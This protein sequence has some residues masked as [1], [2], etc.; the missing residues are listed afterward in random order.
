MVVCIVVVFAPDF[1]AQFSFT[2]LTPLREIS[3]TVLFAP[4]PLLNYWIHLMC[5]GRLW[6]VFFCNYQ[7]RRGG[8]KCERHIYCDLVFCFNSVYCCWICTRRLWYFSY[9]I[10]P[11]VLYGSVITMKQYRT[12]GAYLHSHWHLYPEG[13]GAKQQQ[14]RPY[15]QHN[16]LSS[17]VVFQK[18]CSSQLTPKT[19]I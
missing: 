7:I 1:G 17:C 4:R 15:L 5:T 10:F 16:H 8:S 19:R 13:V 14:V 11:D 12:G 2:H 9:F 3:K 6:S 18:V